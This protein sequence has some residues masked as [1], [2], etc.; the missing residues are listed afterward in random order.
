MADIVSLEAY[1][2]AHSTTSGQGE[3][4][5]S[6]PRCDVDSDV[7]EEL[8][9]LSA[10]NTGFENN[11]SEVNL[12]DEGVVKR[13]FNFIRMLLNYTHEP[14]NRD[15]GFSKDW[16]VES[17]IDGSKIIRADMV[18]D[19]STFILRGGSP[20]LT[21][22]GYYDTGFTIGDLINAARGSQA[23]IAQEVNGYEPTTGINMDEISDLT[24]TPAM[25]Q[26]YFG[27]RFTPDYFLDMYSGEFLPEKLA[28]LVRDY[29][30]YFK[31]PTDERDRENCAEIGC[32][33]SY[34]AADI[35][36][37]KISHFGDQNYIQNGDVYVRAGRDRS[38]LSFLDGT[39]LDQFSTEEN[40]AATI[41]NLANDGLL[42][43]TMVAQLV[44]E[45]KGYF[46]WKR[47]GDGID[48]SVCSLDD[49]ESVEPSY[50]HLVESK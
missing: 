39:G 49:M 17:R 43:G 45:V 4:G 37:I 12:A 24:G 21:D 11:P 50:L 38:F 46:F 14:D 33:T 7:S 16:Y 47:F 34:D 19:I 20:R 40:M 25:L 10:G 2:K 23:K 8:E 35:P 42:P 27:E 29:C 30:K 26:L 18:D 32:P 36:E 9:D 6:I 13:F 22:Y 48:D 44:W 3:D 5:S 1:V 15:D 31:F 28:E 41:Q